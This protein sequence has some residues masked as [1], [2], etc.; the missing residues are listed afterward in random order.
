MRDQEDGL[1]AS[2]SRCAAARCSSGRASSRRARRTARPSGG[3]RDCRTARG[4]S[5]RAGACRPTARAASA[6][7]TRRCRRAASARA[8]AP[9]APP[10][11]RPC[12]SSGSVML[13]S[14]VSHGKRLASWKTMPMPATDIAL[15]RAVAPRARGRARAPSP[16]VGCV[17]PATMRSSVVLP[18]PDGPSST[19]ISP[20]ADREVRRR[21]RVHRLVL[22]LEPFVDAGQH[23]RRRRGGQR[24]R[25]PPSSP[26]HGT[27]MSSFANP[28]RGIIPGPRRRAPAC[29]ARRRRAGA[30]DRI[31]CGSAQSPRVACVAF[32]S[33]V[34]GPVAQRIAVP[35]RLAAA[36]S[37]GPAVPTAPWRSP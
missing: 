6:S 36:A 17:R 27:A 16:L 14:I 33:H 24:G 26:H 7:R 18:Q 19:T 20:V 13:P 12:I 22:R 21:Q 30:G 2:P 11:A 9:A 4:R 28:G 3:C 35:R 10:W 34:L 29:W 31:C 23:D 25:E 8:P 1:A 37:A 5:P 15:A 32:A